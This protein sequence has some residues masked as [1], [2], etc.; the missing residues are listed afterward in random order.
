MVLLYKFCSRKK[1]YSFLYVYNAFYINALA[2]YMFAD[3]VDIVHLL[4]L[5][6]KKTYV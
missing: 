2:V 4:S 3:N 6:I 1:M 5:H